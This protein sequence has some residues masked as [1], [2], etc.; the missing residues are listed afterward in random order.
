MTA[1]IS[2]S[3]AAL[4][5][6]AG[7][8]TQVERIAHRGRSFEPSDSALAELAAGRY[9]HAA[10]MLRA[11]GA[12]EGTPADQLLLARAEAG[13][14]NWG[15]VIELLGR[16]DANAP[17]GLYLLGQALWFAGDWMGAADAYGRF[18]ALGEGSALER[19][20]ADARRARSL[21]R[22][23]DHAA[24]LAGLAGLTGAASVR[25]WLAA[26]LALVAASEGD[27]AG[28]RALLPHVTDLR[29]AQAVWRAEPD[30]RVA[31]S[32]PA[33]ATVAYRVLLSLSE[34]T[35]RGEVAVE[36]GRLLLAA[37]D[38]AEARLR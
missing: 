18:S 11:E 22:A 29:A 19:G 17:A 33:G 20:A 8:S 26:D 27:T 3:F 21:W 2:V 32:D 36:L 35:R 10:T 37:G 13:W 4:L 14:E 25:S 16:S 9:W 7:A 38:S 5:I 28:V 24:A 23:G 15:A 12:A 31:A 34:G 1:R 6:L 30:A